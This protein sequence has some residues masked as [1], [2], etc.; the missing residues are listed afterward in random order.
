MLYKF[1]DACPNTSIL[2]MDF[3]SAVKK[4]FEN[5][6]VVTEFISAKARSRTICIRVVI[7]D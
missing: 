2:R 5:L 6:S 1:L 3:C 4:E 7:H